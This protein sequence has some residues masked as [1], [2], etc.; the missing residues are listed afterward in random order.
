MISLIWITDLLA[1]SSCTCKDIIQNKN[2][3]LPDHNGQIMD[4]SLSYLNIKERVNK[5]VDLDSIT[6][7][8][9]NHAY[10]F[11]GP[12]GKM[13]DIGYKFPLSAQG[14]HHI[15]KIFSDIIFSNTCFKFTIPLN[16]DPM[17]LPTESVVGY[18]T[19]MPVLHGCLQSENKNE[20]AHC[21]Q[22]AIKNDIYNHTLYPK[23]RLAK[24]HD[25]VIEFVVTKAGETTLHRFKK[26]EGD[27]EIIKK[28][29]QDT[30][31]LPAKTKKGD[32]IAY[33]YTLPLK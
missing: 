25:A 16:L 15:K 8:L 4:D 5:L 13:C 6:D 18:T 1:Q 17:L 32:H 27:I 24:S 29:I 9:H 33:L 31:W 7:R 19:Y 21:M 22:S 23:A 12:D 11:V 30:K 14:Q 10:I 28:I 26:G 20:V 2:P 3:T